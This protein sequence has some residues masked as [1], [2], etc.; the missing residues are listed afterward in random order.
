MWTLPDYMGVWGEQSRQHAVDI[1]GMNPDRI[2]TIGT[3]RFEKYFSTK[4]K[5]YSRPYEFPYILFCGCSEPF[6]EINA[7]KRLDR[8]IRE[9]REVYQSMKVVYRPH[10]KRQQRLCEDQ[11][12]EK[13]FENVILDR[14]AEEYYYRKVDRSYQ[15]NLDYYPAL[16]FHAA[17]VIAPLTTILMESLI[18]GR[19]VLALVYDDGVHFTSPHNSLKYYEHF[20]GVDRISGLFFC[21]RKENLG[22][23]VR[24]RMVKQPRV[25]RSRMLSEIRYF[26]YHDYLS[27]PERLEKLVNRVEKEQTANGERKS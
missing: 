25:S 22:P 20:K 1:H 6:D 12:E 4:P 26:L 7:L 24:D 14:Q 27:Y 21:D 3:P 15:P 9:N 11:F 17:F 19:Q 8:E 16:L 18:C 13:G 23:A 5:D 2:D 10:P